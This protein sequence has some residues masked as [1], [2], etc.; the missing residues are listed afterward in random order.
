LGEG[1]T[2]VRDGYHIID[3]DTHVGPNVETLQIYAGP[4][5]VERWDE[6][7][8]YYQP[9]TEGHHLSIS[10]YPFKRSLRTSGMEQAPVKG[11]VIPLKG[12]TALNWEQH[13]APEVNNLNAAGRLADMDAEGV[14]VHLIIP[15]TFANAATTLDNEIA[16]ELYSA[17]HRYLTDYCATDPARLKGSILAAGVDPEWSAARIRELAKEPWVAAVIP[18]LPEGMPLDDPALNP[19]WEAMDE[20]DLPILHHSFFYEPPYF[21]GYRDVWGN[22]AI[23]RAASHP[24]GAQRLLAYALL[25]GMFDEYPNLRI[26]FAECSSGW[27]AGWLNRLDYQQAYLSRTLPETKLTPTEY[28]R[29]GRVFCG[30]E[31]DEGPEITQSVIDVVGDGVLMYSSDYPHGGCKFPTSPDV[32]LAWKSLGEENL[33]KLFS[34]NAARYLRM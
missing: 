30:V 9:V 3:S 1:G 27:V 15:A 13:P 11:G 5:L 17:Y 24:W 19:I 6:L 10:P 29:A 7:L 33:R 12:K 20:S 14:D 31:L 21:P 28:A 22:L 25:S 32:V 16:L 18:V 8:P 23:A 34:D 2:A 4:R 26:G